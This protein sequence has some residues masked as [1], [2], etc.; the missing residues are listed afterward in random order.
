MSAVLEAADADRGWH[1]QLRL[2][3]RADSHRTV[4]AERSRSGPLAVQRSF[5]PEGPVCHTYL[6]HPPGGVVGG[7]RLE[8]D[9]R[10]GEAAHAL[11]TTPGAAKFYRSNGLQ[12]CQVQRLSVADGAT[13]EW[14]PQENIFF[15]GATARL[16]TRV[17]LHG[18]ARIAL[19]EI[20]CLGRPAVDEAFAS[21]HI[22]ARLAI[23][24]DGVPLLLER[25]RV[26]PDNRCRLS[27]MAGMAVGGM[28]VF[29]HA[30]EA[31]VE[32]CRDLLY[33]TGSDYVGAT[34]I[35]DMLVV[36]YLGDS[37]ARARAL[38]IAAWQLLR[39]LTLG[40]TAQAPRI[41]AT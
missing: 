5:Y 16:D 34:L 38:F 14:L 1:A 33:G 8:I 36:R 17:S 26:D 40:R 13:L 3:Y 27:L 11:L 21:G 25:L 22:D 29:S 24:R 31:Q 20:H 9:V 2:G 15:P 10:V 35:E 6:L 32:A 7:D 19:W 39:P 12:A 18:D 28:L 37:T 4:L 30:S 41:W 23:E